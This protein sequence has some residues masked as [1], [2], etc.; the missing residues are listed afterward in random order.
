MYA[1]VLSVVEIWYTVLYSMSFERPCCAT[2]TAT[3]QLCNQLSASVVLYSTVPQVNHCQENAP[4]TVARRFS[5]S[6]ESALLHEV[7]SRPLTLGRR[8]VL[9]LSV[10]RSV[11]TRPN[12][13]YPGAVCAPERLLHDRQGQ[14]CAPGRSLRCVVQR[15]LRHGNCIRA[16]LV[17]GDNHSGCVLP[18]FLQSLGHIVAQQ[19]LSAIR[20]HALA[21]ASDGRNGDLVSD[22]ARVRFLVWLA[23]P[24]ARDNVVALRMRPRTDSISSMVAA[25]G[26]PPQAPMNV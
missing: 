20:H 14:H 19:E 15:S 1:C 18:Q 8:L 21:V 10:A 12:V 16:H 26:I 25:A 7:D 11:G 3:L 17:V 9:L 24:A 23:V 6:S 13:F 22:R 4:R 2:V 5:R